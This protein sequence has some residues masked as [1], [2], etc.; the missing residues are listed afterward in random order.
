[1]GCSSSPRG[2]PS[3]LPTPASSL[4]LLCAQLPPNPAERPVSHGEL[5]PASAYQP[6]SLVRP[7]VP[8]PNYRSPP[9]RQLSEE[10]ANLQE[11][12][13]KETQE[14]K[15]LS[16]TNEELLWKLQTGDPTSPIKL[17]PTSPVYRGSSSGPSSPARVSTTPR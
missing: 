16:R 6:L 12:V 4:S 1:M 13:E 3:P 8:A 11:Y 15:R 10:N 7:M 14:K 2:L 9:R 5:P 17:S